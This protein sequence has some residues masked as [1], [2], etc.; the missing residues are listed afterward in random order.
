MK[1][2]KNT[3][4]TV[5]LACTSCASINKENI[6]P[7]YVQAFETVNSLIFGAKN[8]NLTP[9][10]INNIPYASSTLTIGRGAPGLI[11]LEST[12]AGLDTWVSADKVFLIIE[13][14]RIIR[15]SG[16]NNNLT[17]FATPL[18]KTLISANSSKLNYYYSYDEPFLVDLKVSA[19][20]RVIGRQQVKL[21][22][23]EIE[24]TLI[25]EHISN[26]YLGWNAVNKFWVD[27]SNFVWKSEQHISPKLPVFKIEVTKKPAY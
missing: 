8:K 21:I 14:G 2:F 27:E 12:I 26:D 9:E 7:G 17:Y 24:L 1:E 18:K 22:N 6:A 25:E 11:I 19:E 15:T 16:I 4:L 5:V 10:L 20:I 23:K 3:L 13:N